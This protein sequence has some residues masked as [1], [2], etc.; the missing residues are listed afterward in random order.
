MTYAVKIENYEGPLELLLELVSKERMDVADVS[1]SVITGEYLR[2]VS[3]MGELDLDVATS[4]LILAA[5]L[6][7]LKSFKLLPS[8][9]A[10]DPELAA[11][12]EERD[13]LV[14]RLIEY[15]TFKQVAQLFR[16]RL[17]KNAGFFI[18]KADLP[19]ELLGPPPDMLE[20]LSIDM[21]GRAAARALTPKPDPTVDVTHVTPITVSIGE[22]VAMLVRQ[23]EQSGVATFKAL[24]RSATGRIHVIV[25]FLA[26]LEMFKDQKV[27]LE[28]RN[29]FDEIVVRWRQP[30]PEAQP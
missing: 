25:R 4:F 19:K 12:L 2:V 11:L 17:T 1:I 27:E 13:H 22:T 6:L 28:Q 5:T 15:S 9:P 24:C 29:P 26:L 10:G 16:D 21:L 20:G 14:H 23:I 7:E 3:G 8:R 30:L 18:R